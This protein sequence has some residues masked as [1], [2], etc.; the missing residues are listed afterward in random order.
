MTTRQRDMRDDERPTEGELA[1]MR[2]LIE[3]AYGAA[4]QSGKAGIAAGLMRDGHM[5][6][7]GANHAHLESNPT[8]HAEIVATDLLDQSDLSDGCVSKLVEILWR[9]SPSM[10]MWT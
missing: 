3:T 7:D 8:R 1:A 6:A 5:F 4:R 2:A 10:L 9:R